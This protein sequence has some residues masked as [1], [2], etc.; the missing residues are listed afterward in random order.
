MHPEISHWL[1]KYRYSN[2]IISSSIVDR[3]NVALKLRPYNVITVTDRSIPLSE[4]QFVT[5]FMSK[6]VAATATS[7]LKYKYELITPYAAEQQDLLRAF[8]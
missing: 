6:L 5:K 2:R 7:K 8:E 1:N 4:K 3:P